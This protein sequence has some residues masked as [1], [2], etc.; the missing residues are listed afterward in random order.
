MKSQPYI[1][2]LL[3]INIVNEA[4]RKKHNK[5]RLDRLSNQ[6]QSPKEIPYY[7]L[8]STNQ[9]SSANESK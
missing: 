4:I 6:S 5:S 7:I 3:S 1:C 2:K 9:K 8:F